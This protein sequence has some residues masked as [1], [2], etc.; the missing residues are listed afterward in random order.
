MYSIMRKGVFHMLDAQLRGV[1][2][3]RVMFSIDVDTTSGD[4]DIHK[5]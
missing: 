5:N 3:D 4:L 2:G 1:F